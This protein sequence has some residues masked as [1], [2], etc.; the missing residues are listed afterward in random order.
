[1][2]CGLSG[3][4]REDFEMIQKIAWWKENQQSWVFSMEI[5]VVYS[6]PFCVI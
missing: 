2:Q 3:K 1:M 5:Y 4:I 6:T